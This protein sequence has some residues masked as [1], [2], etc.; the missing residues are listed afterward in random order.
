MICG[1][2]LVAEVAVC[3]PA[4]S[5]HSLPDSSNTKEL[6]ALPHL[7]PGAHSYA[8]SSEC[9]ASVSL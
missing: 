8:P 5:A 4:A 2:L 9:C 3:H 1:L 6:L 7:V